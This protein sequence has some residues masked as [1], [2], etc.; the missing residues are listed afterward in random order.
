M[1]VAVNEGV[2]IVLQPLVAG[3]ITNGSEGGV[4]QLPDA[5]GDDIGH[6]EEL[7]SVI[8]QQPVIIPKIWTGHVPV[9]ILGFHVKRKDVSQQFAQADRDFFHTFWR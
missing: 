2:I 7:L 8:V 1:A 3:D 5:L 6:F 9:K 4:P